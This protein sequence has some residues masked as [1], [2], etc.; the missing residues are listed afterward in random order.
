MGQTRILALDGM[1]MLVRVAAV[2][3]A[4]RVSKRKGKSIKKN[5]QLADKIETKGTVLL[6]LLL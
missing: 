4:A 1:M 3:V 2:V 6:C 5:K